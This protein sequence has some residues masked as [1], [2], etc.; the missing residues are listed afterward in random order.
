MVSSVDAFATVSSTAMNKC[1]RFICR[2]VSSDD[3]RSPVRF[4]K[5]MNSAFP[6]SSNIFTSM[7]HTVHGLSRKYRL[8][9]HL[10]NGLFYIVSIV[11]GWPASGLD[12][13][14]V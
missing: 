12:F 9:A 5:I 8:S 14:V 7:L 4:S 2:V 11:I 13:A 1:L 3:S 10:I 6:L